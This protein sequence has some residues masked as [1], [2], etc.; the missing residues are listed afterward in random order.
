MERTG[1]TVPVAVAEAVIAGGGVEAMVQSMQ[2]HPF[3]ARLQAVSLCASASAPLLSLCLPPT[4]SV[5]LSA[6]ICLSVCL[7]LA[8]LRSSPLLP[9]LWEP[10]G[11]RSPGPSGAEQRRRRTCR[12]PGTD[13]GGGMGGAAREHRCRPRK[14]V[15]RHCRSCPPHALALRRCAARLLSPPTRLPI[16][17]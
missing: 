8:I 15:A 9:C 10:A 3:D 5:H 12:R 13:S 6:C 2:E 4:V 14:P 17:N 1:Q 7:L 16:R 11:G